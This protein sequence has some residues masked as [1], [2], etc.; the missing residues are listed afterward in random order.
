VKRI[1]LILGIG[2]ALSVFVMV[3]PLAS[4]QPAPPREPA[5]CVLP[6]VA[7]APSPR[8]LLSATLS[9]TPVS[10]GHQVVVSGVVRASSVAEAYQLY[11]HG[12]RVSYTLWGD[13]PDGDDRLGPDQAVARLE[14]EIQGDRCEGRVNFYSS[15]F[16]RSASAYGQGYLDEDRYPPDGNGTSLANRDEV[17]AEVRSKDSRVETHTVYGFF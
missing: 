14:Y 7:G 2:A 17:Y 15:R 6:P 9:I 4:A 12:S 1:A 16:Y 11:K 10:D 8:P 5:P 3:A 13:D